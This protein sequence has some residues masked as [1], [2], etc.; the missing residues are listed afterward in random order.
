MVVSCS[1]NGQK[2]EMKDKNTCFDIKLETLRNQSIYRD[3]ISQFVDTFGVFEDSNRIFG[4]PDVVANKIDESVFFNSKKDECLLL[5]LQKFTNKILFG[6]V[7]LIR[8]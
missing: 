7:R 4:R 3:V 8:G 6:Q 2:T 1:S 5:V